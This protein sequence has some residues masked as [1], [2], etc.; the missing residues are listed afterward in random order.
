MEKFSKLKT[1]IGVKEKDDVLYQND[2]MT[3]INHEDW[4]FIKER[5]AVICIPYLIESNQI[6]IRQ[7]WIPSYQYADGQEFHLALVGGSIE[8][9]ET[10]EVALLRELQEE[11]GIVLRDNFK[12]EFDQPLF[13]A[14]H[15]SAKYY[16]VILTLTESD[17][18]E[19]SP[20]TDGSKFEQMSKTGKIDIKY[21]SGLNASDILT[22]MMLMKLKEYLNIPASKFY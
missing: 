9:G 4:T 5:D 18:H 21:V 6:V 14:K 12:I 11:A 2:H 20:T 1:Q 3:V 10:P 17:Y 7:E 19:I 15:C 22:E 16:P 8:Q 13:V